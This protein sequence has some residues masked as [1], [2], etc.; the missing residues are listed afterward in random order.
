MAHLK[1]KLG[2]ESM[3]VVGDSDL[4]CEYVGVLPGFIGREVQIGVLARPEMNVVIIG[5]V[6][7]WE[8]SEYARDAISL[9]LPK[10]LIVLGH[11]A[12]EEPACRRLSPGCRSASPACRSRLCRPAGCSALSSLFAEQRPSRFCG[13]P[14][15]QQNPRIWSPARGQFCRQRWRPSC[16]L[17]EGRVPSGRLPKPPLTATNRPMLRPTVFRRTVRV[18][19]NPN[20]ISATRG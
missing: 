17:G 12:S 16:D 3:R 9:G 15:L 20:D 14:A 4:R 18:S 8:T 5:E 1:A 13:E 19:H 11:A 2:V 6:H 10:A 7:E